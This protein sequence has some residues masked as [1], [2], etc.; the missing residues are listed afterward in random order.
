MD[1]ERTWQLFYTGKLVPIEMLRGRGLA[2]DRDF[3][4][5]KKNITYQY[6]FKRKNENERGKE[7]VKSH[8]PKEKRFKLN[9]ANRMEKNTVYYLVDIIMS[10]LNSDDVYMFNPIG[11]RSGYKY[12]SGEKVI[13]Y[14]VSECMSIKEVKNI[15]KLIR[16][17]IANGQ[18]IRNVYKIVI[19]NRLWNGL[20]EW[21]TYDLGNDTQSLTDVVF[22]L[23]KERPLN[24][25]EKG[26][27]CQSTNRNPVSGGCDT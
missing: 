6:R 11:V 2:N 22:T 21:K 24:K 25:T 15:T 26:S 18:N 19:V 1:D 7:A 23:W 8:F 17:E 20:K 9:L 3:E 16:S 5:R 27:G 10:L 12:Y 4:L 14:Q 13:V